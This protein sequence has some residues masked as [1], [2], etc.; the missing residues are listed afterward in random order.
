MDL[1]GKSEGIEVGGC[2][3]I[4]H[5]ASSSL[6]QQGQ[7]HRAAQKGAA[8]GCA[9]PL[10]GHVDQLSQSPDVG[11]S[12]LAIIEIDRHLLV[13]AYFILG[14]LTG[15]LDDD[16]QQFGQRIANFQAIQWMLADMATQIDAARLLT[17]RAAYL[18]DEGLP[19]V[20][21]GAMAKVFAAEI[22]MFVT[23]KAIQI[24][25]GYGYTK[26]LV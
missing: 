20:K 22:A 1:R 24:Y 2:S 5:V 10:K 23:T 8:K 4:M 11:I 3:A 21:E 9:L 16:R 25:G 13:V 18:E 15:I 6:E 14:R 7:H 12:P 17:Y 19:F 26:A